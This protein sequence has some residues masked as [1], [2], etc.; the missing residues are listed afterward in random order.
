MNHFIS[1]EASNCIRFF[2]VEISKQERI[3]F[4]VDVVE[5]VM[6]TTLCGDKIQR[7]IFRIYNQYICYHH[8]KVKCGTKST[9][10]NKIELI[11]MEV[12]V[13]D[14]IKIGS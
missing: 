5:E 13:L 4:S 6:V 9:H 10:G 12:K 1:Q 8:K 7:K 11:K 3:F 14:R 2:S